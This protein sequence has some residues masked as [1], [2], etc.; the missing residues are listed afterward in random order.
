MVFQRKR[1]TLDVLASLLE[2]LQDGSC[3]RSA[4]ASR[5][6]LA[7]RSAT[8]YTD[9]ALRFGLIT[10]EQSTHLFKI[11]D[12]GRDFMVHYKKLRALVGE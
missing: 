8:R 12:N 7:T 2:I 11:T 3:N 6:N 9:L 10:K 1:G 4:L 5:A